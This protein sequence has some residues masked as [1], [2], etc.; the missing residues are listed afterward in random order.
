MLEI[1]QNYSTGTIICLAFMIFLL[2]NGNFSPRTNRLFF[3]ATGCTLLLLVLNALGSEALALSRSFWLAGQ[4]AA[5]VLRCAIPYFLLLISMRNKH[6]PKT[7]FL[8]SLPL[9]AA[10]AL[11]CVSVFTGIAFSFDAA[12]QPIRGPLYFLPFAVVAGYIAWLTVNTAANYLQKSRRGIFFLLVLDIVAL[13]AIFAEILSKSALYAVFSSLCA[14]DIVF[15][16]LLLYQFKSNC[17]RLT[18][19]LGRRQFFLDAKSASLT[20]VIALDLNG[21]KYI[22]DTHGHAEGDGALAKMAETV[23]SVLPKN[24]AMYRV[25]GDEFSI[26]CR[27][28]KEEDVKFL[29]EQIRSAMEPSGYTWASGYAMFRK[30]N[31][32]GTTCLMADAAMYENKAAMRQDTLHYFRCG[33]LSMD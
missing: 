21:L 10:A 28:M 1:L 29:M 17:D 7:D 33:T 30:E 14:F 13:T 12:G 26:L 4:A 6:T 24:A 22:N 25:G 3:C 16:Y 18:G 8:F 5:Y 23:R 27:R 2:S 15:Y 11:S 32:F 19:C 9:F 31:G 20:A